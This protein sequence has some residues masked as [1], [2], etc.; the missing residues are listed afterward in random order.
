MYGLPQLNTTH[1]TKEKEILLLH[2]DYVTEYMTG[3]ATAVI[4]V[5]FH[6]TDTQSSKQ[7]LESPTKPITTSSKGKKI[8]NF[9]KL[10]CTLSE[11]QYFDWHSTAARLHMHHMCLR[12]SS[13]CVSMQ[14]VEQGRHSRGI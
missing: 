6:L 13:T 7:H 3:M 2:W 4:H 9:S 5:S 12:N 8:I 1:N 14:N 11:S 10:C